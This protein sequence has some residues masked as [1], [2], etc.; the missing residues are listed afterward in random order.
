MKLY[1]T[2]H[3]LRMQEAVMIHKAARTNCLADSCNHYN[4][5]GE[6]S[7]VIHDL[8]SCSL[9]M[10]ILVRNCRDLSVPCDHC[11]PETYHFS[12]TTEQME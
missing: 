12:T 11:S 1:K 3:T 5:N 7:T 2:K 8:A 9:R 4:Y 10:R 6:A